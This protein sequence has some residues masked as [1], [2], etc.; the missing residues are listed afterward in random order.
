MVQVRVGV[1]ERDGFELRGLER[2]QDALRLVS[3]VDDDRLAR[4]RVREDRAVALER[5]DRERLDEGPGAQGFTATT[6][7]TSWL[8]LRAGQAQMRAVEEAESWIAHS[9]LSGCRRC[10]AKSLRRLLGVK[11]SQRT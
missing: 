5:P 1:K 2:A 10:D 4:D 11:I 6:V 9:W 3:G 7:S 8:S